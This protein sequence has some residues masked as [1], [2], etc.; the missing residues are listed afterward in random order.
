MSKNFSILLTSSVVP[1]DKTVLLKDQ[2]QRIYYT[3]ESI[4]EWLKVLPVAKIVICDG[5][6]FDFSSLIKKA[7]P[8]SSIECLFF[9][10]D[11]KKIED[12]G[13]GYG[14]GEI[15]KFAL[16]HSKY[17]QSS[18]WFVKCTAKLWVK[19]FEMLLPRWNGSLLLK[20]YIS[21]I[22]S[23]SHSRLEYIDTRFYM[24]SK[25]LYEGLFINAHVGID[26]LNGIGL[27]NIFLDIVKEEGLKKIFFTVSP[28]IA[29]VGGGSGKYYNF[30]TTRCIKE[31]IRTYVASCNSR[32]KNFFT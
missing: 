21:R 7:F 25:H 14:E 6:N 26:T 4:G 28:I 23:L 17:L 29:G 16:K 10:N 31:N 13:K 9:L 32:Y 3:L 5:S 19:N 18:S 30:S 12:L 1:M 20:P 2:A 8:G 15:I 24:I 22:F 27:E 11:E